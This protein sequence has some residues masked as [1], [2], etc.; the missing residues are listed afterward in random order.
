[1][2]ITATII[3]TSVRHQKSLEIIKQ[4]ME[5]IYTLYGQGYGTN[6]MLQN[7]E[8]KVYIILSKMEY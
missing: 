4:Q 6:N 7:C 3:R 1:M 5:R 8:N 2:I